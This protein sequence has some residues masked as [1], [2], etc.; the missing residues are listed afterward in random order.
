MTN[1]AR[2]ERLA[3]CTTFERVG[4][5]APTLCAGW[6]TGDLAAHLV[7]REGRPD[8]LVAQLVPALSRHAQSLQHKVYERS[9]ADLVGSVRSGPPLWHPTRLSVVDEV[10]NTAEFFV[11]HEDVLRAQPS[12]TPR[13]I[14]DDLQRALWRTCTVVGRL[15]L[16]KAEVGVEFVAPGYGRVM[17]RKGQPLVRVEGPPAEL[18][19][20]AFGRR[21]VAQ[22][23]LEGP[24]VAV[25]ALRAARSAI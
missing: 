11:H 7:I 24:D 15:A 17:V 3:L 10:A 2:A 14:A 12:W 23:Q 18:T 25:A 1:H 9:F 19:L 8:A 4:E 20:F 22:V 16:R 5:H 13:P 21:E 6:D